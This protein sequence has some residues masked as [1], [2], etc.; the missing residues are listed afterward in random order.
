MSAASTPVRRGFDRLPA[1]L[2]PRDAEVR[3][4]GQMRLIET[5]LLLLAGLLLA[6][7]TV[8]DVVLQTHTNHRLVA[9]LRTWRTYTGHDYRNLSAEQD[10]RNHSTRD[11]V[12]GNTTPGPPKERVQLCLQMTGP[13]IH[14]RRAARGGWY[15]PPKAEDLRGYRYGCFGTT[16]E[17]GACTR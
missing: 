10:Q 5:T 3:G 15:L 4:T 8:N 13:V 14:G 16:R 6:L 12:C 2:R 17:Q 7:A 1:W 9:D 11:V